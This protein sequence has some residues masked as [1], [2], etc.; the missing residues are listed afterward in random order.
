MIRKPKIGNLTE[1]T[2][3][4]LFLESKKWYLI[5]KGIFRHFSQVANF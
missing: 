4:Y 3:L 5:F 1:E 2:E